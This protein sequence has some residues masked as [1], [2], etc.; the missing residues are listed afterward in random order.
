MNYKVK[1]DIFE[2]PFDLL[3]YL[4]ENA[5]MSIY[6]IKIAEITD[7]YIDYLAR[8]QELN[9]AVAGEFMVLA[10]QLLEIKSR[11]I[12]PRPAEEGDA[13]QGEDPRLELTRKLLEYKR[14][15]LI[16]QMLQEQEEENLRIFEKPQEDISEFTENPDEYLS[17]SLPEFSKAFNNFLHRK[18]KLEDIRRNYVRVKRER[19]STESR[20]GFIRDICKRYG[21]KPVNFKAS[22]KDPNDRYDVVLSFTSVLEMVN[23]KQ[24]DAEQKKIYGDIM[25]RGKEQTAQE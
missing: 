12:L 24:L 25:L 18:K 10:A 13:E 15:K 23:A 8:M 2:G 20:M 17:L 21:G 1:L 4:I 9:I 6:D 5:R 7:Q 11:M 3:V 14:F 19:A 22:I 16:S